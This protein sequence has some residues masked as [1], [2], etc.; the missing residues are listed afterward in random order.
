MNVLDAAYVVLR[1]ANEPLHYRTLT[2][3]MLERGLWSTSGK[4]PAD[5]V[6]ARLSTD[7]TRLGGASRFRRIERGMYE[8][9]ESP[10]DESQS[11]QASFVGDPI[12]RATEAGRLAAATRAASAM[13]F[14]DAAAEV[15]S[16]AAGPMH[17]TMI[18]R[19]AIDR[20]LIESRG[21]TPA[22]TMNAVIGLEIRRRQDRGEQ[23]R[24][25]RLGGGMIGLVEPV[26]P[27][28]A[29]EIEEHNCEV[30]RGLLARLGQV[31]PDEF[32]ALI[33]VLLAALGFEEVGRTPLSGDGGIDVRGTLIV[34]DVVRIRMAIQ[35]KRWKNNV[36]RPEVQKVRGSLG[37][38]EQGLIITTSDFSKSAREEAERVDASPVALMNGE[39]LAVLLAANEIGVGHA[40]YKLLSLDEAV[41]AD[42]AATLNEWDSLEDEAASH[43]L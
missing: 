20:G 16:A 8:V 41:E 18:T 38:H 4:T 29:A 37:A 27:S 23:P 34:G 40:E 42:L 32:E 14:V 9:S 31:A 5:T 19:Q 13:S 28:L 43:G 6:S 21:K 7:I 1:E 22:D 3:R 36:Q 35:A 17:Y 25:E 15:L 10:G 2:E 39:Q 30:R 11:A 24:F 33:E 26:S 12:N